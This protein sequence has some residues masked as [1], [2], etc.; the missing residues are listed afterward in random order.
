MHRTAKRRRPLCIESRIRPDFIPEMVQQQ[1]IREL[2]PH[3]GKPEDPARPR[4]HR[5]VLKRKA[6][7]ALRRARRR[8]SRSSDRQTKNTKEL[9]LTHKD[10]EERRKKTSQSR[11]LGLCYL[12]SSRRSINI[13]KGRTGF[14]LLAY[15]C[16]LLSLDGGRIRR[17]IRDGHRVRRRNGAG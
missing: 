14:R 6:G 5:G 2:R 7:L 11:T 4:N 16:R 8:P 17:I 10:M 12:R 1:G 3:N 13:H 9:T 15:I